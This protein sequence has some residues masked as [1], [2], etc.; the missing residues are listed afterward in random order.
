MVTTKVE[1]KAIKT[2]P[3]D[4]NTYAGTVDMLDYMGMK[5]MRLNFLAHVRDCGDP[6]HVPVFLELS[7]KPYD[8]AIWDQLK[9]GEETVY[10]Q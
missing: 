3:G 1:I 4:V 2:E 8:D 9:A 6:G 5:P 10:A 7:P